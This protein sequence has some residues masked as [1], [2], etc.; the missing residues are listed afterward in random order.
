MTKSQKFFS[1]IAH[2]PLIAV[3]RGLKPND[4]LAVGQLL[5]DAGITVL[6]VPVRKK[7][8]NFAVL[9]VESIRSIEILANKFGREVIVGAGTVKKVDDVAAVSQAGGEIIVSP[10][11]VPT[12][13]EAA[14]KAGLICT[15]GVETLSEAEAAFNLGAT[16]VKIFPCASKHPVSGDIVYRHDPSYVKMLVDFLPGP[17]Y[18]SGGINLD[19]MAAYWAAGVGAL[20][21][22]G[23]LYKPGLS[24]DQ[25]S[26]RAGAYVKKAKEL[27]MQNGQATDCAAA[28]T[29]VLRAATA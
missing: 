20:N 17:V 14:V 16:G 27:Q 19:N 4:A 26:A 2:T 21:I 24:L 28:N 7:A 23:D 12:V 8:D 22:G 5:V 3:L 29:K 15:P 1:C 10:N 9:D 6:E 18:P 11:S 13:I 25:L